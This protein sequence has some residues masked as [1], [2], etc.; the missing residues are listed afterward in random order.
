MSNLQSQ[1]ANALADTSHNAINVADLNVG[2]SNPPQQF[3]VQAIIDKINE[4][5]SVLRR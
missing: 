3:E 4:L 1:I 5:L 2:L